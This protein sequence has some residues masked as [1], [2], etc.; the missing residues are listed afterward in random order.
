[1]RFRVAVDVDSDQHGPAPVHRGTAVPIA[2]DAPAG[3]SAHRV[4][5]ADRVNRV[6]ARAVLVPRAIRPK[7]HHKRVHAGVPEKRHVQ[8]VHRV[9]RVRGVAVLRTAP[10]PVRLPLSTDI[11]QTE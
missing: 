11:P 1:M 3:R 10:V 2:A 5:V 8:A 9:H 6:H 7:Q 4:H